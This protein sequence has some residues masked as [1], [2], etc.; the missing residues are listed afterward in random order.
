MGGA[1]GSIDEAETASR[2]SANRSLSSSGGPAT[3]AGKSATSA[4]RKHPEKVPAFLA[5]YR[6]CATLPFLVTDS[7]S[8]VLAMRWF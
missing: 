1:M 7:I 2:A 5:R 8:R 3:S 6:H 4:G